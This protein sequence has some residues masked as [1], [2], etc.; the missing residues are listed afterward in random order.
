MTKKWSGSIVRSWLNYSFSN[1]AFSFEEQQFLCYQQRSNPPIGEIKVS[2]KKEKIQGDKPTID[3]VFLLSA[4]EIEQYL[5]TP[6]SRISPIS[7]YAK[8]QKRKM[9]SLVLYRL[10][11][12]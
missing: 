4:E 3:F 11:D 7:E 8:S 10:M 1:N 2:G 6:Q 12:G 9:S 5:T